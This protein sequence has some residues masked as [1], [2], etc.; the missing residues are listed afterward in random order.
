MLARQLAHAVGGDG[1]AVGIGLVVQPRQ[2]VDEVEVVALHHL[3]PVVGAVAVGHHLRKGAFV[4]G[5]VVEADRAG[6]DGL[7]RQAGHHGHHGAGIHAAGQKGAQRHLGDHAQAHGF[8]DARHQFGLRVGGRDGVVQREAHVPVFTR[9][10]QRLA[11]LHQQAVAGGQLARLAEDGA[12]L[13]H[14]AQR[15]ILLDGLRV[16]VTAHAAVRQHRLQLRPEEQRAVVQQCVVQRLDAQAVA[17]H[18][19]ALALAVPDGKGKHASQALH[20]VFAP[21]LPGVHDALG[22]ALGVE[23]MP[24]GLQLGDQVLVVVDLAVEDDDHRAV[25]VEQRLLARGHVDDGQP[26]VAEAQ[27]GL[28]VQAA[29]VGPAV[30]LRRIHA[31]K[32][33]VVD[34]ALATGVEE[35]GD[36]AH[37]GWASCKS[38]G[39]AGPRPAGGVANGD[40]RPG[41]RQDWG[42]GAARSGRA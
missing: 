8:T 23:D 5:R 33:D 2:R 4:E 25:F 11:V 42:P 36:A 14:V 39:C 6:V 26:P 40:G 1:A 30:G 29:L 13:G 15:E 3:Q 35:A 22:V 41:R 34:G 9:G 17:R 37:G 16:Q 32:D 19:Q 27:P 18:E 38:G 24:Q 7:G 28:D 21:G 20:A 10:R 31:A 12:R